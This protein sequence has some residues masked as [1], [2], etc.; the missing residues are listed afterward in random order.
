MKIQ[1]RLPDIASIA[2]IAACL[3]AAVLLVGSLGF[4][5]YEDA[6]LLK[7]APQVICPSDTKRL[8]QQDTRQVN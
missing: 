2:A 7:A 5:I 1:E 8:V 3:I 4:R 6:A